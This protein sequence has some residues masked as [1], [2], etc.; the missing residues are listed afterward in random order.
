MLA[1]F[2]RNIHTTVDLVNL[3]HDLC[4][5]LKIDDVK[6]TNIFAP[7]EEGNKPTKKSIEEISIILKDENVALP[8]VGIWSLLKESHFFN[9]MNK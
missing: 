9:N 2:L 7:N 3:R 1:L 6:Y 8:S 5:V 4:F